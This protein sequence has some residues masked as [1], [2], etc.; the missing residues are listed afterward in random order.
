VSNSTDPTSSGGRQSRVNQWTEALAHL[1][2]AILILDRS[3]APPHV[4]AEIDLAI[5]RLRD[6]IASEPEA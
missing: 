3:E 4:G 1:Q 5:N 2:Q 6:V